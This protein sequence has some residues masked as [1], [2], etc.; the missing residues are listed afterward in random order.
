M[1]IELNHIKKSFYSLIAELDAVSF[2]LESR[3]GT[4]H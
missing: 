1:Q 4:A 2:I 3:S